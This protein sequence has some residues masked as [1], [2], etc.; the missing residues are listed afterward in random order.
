MKVKKILRMILI[1]SAVMVAAFAVFLYKMNENSKK[2]K[3]EIH[4]S[5]EK[6]CGI[7]SLQGENY[8]MNIPSTTEITD[9]V[10]AGENVNVLIFE[11]NGAQDIYS[12]EHTQK[13]K[14]QLERMQ[15]KKE[16]TF[17]APL[18]AYNPY[19]TNSCGLYIYFK[20]EEKTQLEYT[21]SIPDENVPDFSRTMKENSLHGKNE[22]EYLL[23]GLV[24][25]MENY[26]RVRL[27]S[28]SG[29]EIKTMVYRINMPASPYGNASAVVCEYVKEK[30]SI[31]N[32][33]F[34]AYGVG[35]CSIPAYD[36]AG[37]LREEFPLIEENALGIDVAGASMYI[38]PSDKKIA[39]LSMTGEVLG[40]VDVGEYTITNDVAYNGIGNILALASKDARKTKGD[41]IIK[42]NFENAS[43]EEIIDFRDKLKGYY[44]AYAKKEKKTDWLGIN[45]IEVFNKNDLLVSAGGISSIINVQNVMTKNPIIKYI[46]GDEKVW[47][48]AEM[49]DFLLTRGYEEGEEKE[50]TGILEKEV[51][52]EVVNQTGVVPYMTV[53]NNNLYDEEG[54]YVPTPTYY[55]NTLNNTNGVNEFMRL[56]IDEEA[57]TYM[58]TNQVPIENVMNAASISSIEANIVVN[59][60]AANII[61]EISVD[62]QAYVRL[63]VKAL[64]AEKF[65]MKDY[66]FK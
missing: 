7:V 30:K 52:F 29:K 62:G 12:T 48:K 1:V 32:G 37:Y 18:L 16:Y 41:V 60:A 31:A 13:I 23:T 36:N 19:G 38:Q 66:W 24:P 8:S 63:N 64:K 4:K 54:N 53:D 9:L 46:I 2:L 56:K 3:D 15:L 22:Y 50:D 43:V 26:L 17:E 57:K 21:V 44:K 61:Q 49:T 14:Q 25:G 10:V 28:D 47:K 42:I 55:L 6:E 58:L 45:D 35:T 39:K 34:Y 5:A 27:L 11:A 33:L 65:S 59:D 51:P 40:V 20:T